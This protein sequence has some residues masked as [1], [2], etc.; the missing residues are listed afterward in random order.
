[1]LLG[2]I[3]QALMECVSLKLQV[4]ETAAIVDYL[5]CPIYALCSGQLR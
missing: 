5:I 2:K 1:M 3:Q 4:R